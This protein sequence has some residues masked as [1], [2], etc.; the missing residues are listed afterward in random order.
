MRTAAIVGGGI[1]G[2]ATAIGLS[3]RGWQVRVYEQAAGFTEVGSGIS[4]WANALRA[5]DALG[6]GEQVRARGIRPGRGG[7]R[8]RRGRW[9]MRD[10]VAPTEL[11][12]LHRADLLRILLDAVPPESLRP[13][14]RVDTPGIEDG[15]AVV[16]S[17][18]VDL[19]VGADGLRSRVRRTFWPQAPEPRYTG[20]SA[21]RMLVP[22]KEIA[23][24]DGCE[25]WRDG[26]VFGAFPMGERL[27]CYAAAVVPENG[28]GKLAELR[29]RYAGWPDPIPA[30]LAAAEEDTVLRHD[31]YRLPPLPSYVHGPVVLLGD[32]AHAMPPS[33]GQGA[34]Q[35]LEDAATLA[36]LASADDLT[37]GLA[38]Y[39]AARRPRTQAISRRSEAAGKMAHLAWRPAA[40]ARDL[41][42]RVV[43]S[44]LFLRSIAPLL[45]WRPPA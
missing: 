5:L 29:A 3:R 30:V 10:A 38:C 25:T 21:W 44:S 40:A 23:P 9:I 31:L 15:R 36:A 13:G 16:G 18:T 17:S 34:C 1:G 24:F 37:A 43:P 11:V 32:A 33:L 7:F 4:L 2:L 45:D 41:G 27:Y 39:D 8:D 20:R 26:L 22:A 28:R 12:M 6:V 19:L 42:L 14:E 35:A